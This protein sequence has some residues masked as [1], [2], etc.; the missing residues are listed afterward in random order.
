MPEGES[1]VVVTNGDV[2]TSEKLD[3][4]V[5]HFQ[6]KREANPGHQSTIMVVPFRSPYG[7]VDVNGMDYVDG[8]QEKVELPYWIN[9]GVY[10][11][12]REVQERLPELG[13]H[14]DSTF[15]ALAAEGKLSA[16]RS[17]AFWRSVDSFK[18]L[19]ETEDYLRSS[20]SARRGVG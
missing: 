13:D 4:L 20:E 9:G 12:S 16:L 2:I 8:F 19:R 18:D 11:F 10:V 7:L 5:A 6:K 1:F 3:H 14:E 17:R 15:P